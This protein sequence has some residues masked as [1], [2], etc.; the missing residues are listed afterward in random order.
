MKFPPVLNIVYLKKI[1]VPHDKRLEISS[2]EKHIKHKNLHVSILEKHTHN[3]RH[4]KAFIKE[5][6]AIITVPFKD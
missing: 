2:V 4:D 1:K 3:G 5:A 6:H